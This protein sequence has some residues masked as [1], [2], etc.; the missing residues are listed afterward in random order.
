M[1][2]EFG[3]ILV[4]SITFVPALRSKINRYWHGRI[5]F[6]LIAITA[7]TFFAFMYLAYSNGM[8]KKA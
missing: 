1:K 3:F 2:I 6:G 8:I 7:I 4:L 5:A